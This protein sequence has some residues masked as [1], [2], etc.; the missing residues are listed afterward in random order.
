MENVQKNSSSKNNV[1]QKYIDLLQLI[2]I[3]RRLSIK[4]P[5]VRPINFFGE[6]NNRTDGLHFILGSG[7]SGACLPINL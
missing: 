2:V 1:A 6:V 4:R 5:D 3:D 7:L